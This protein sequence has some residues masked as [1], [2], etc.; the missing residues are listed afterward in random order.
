M[1]RIVAALDI[2]MPE[3]SL[4]LDP[5]RGI[6]APMAIARYAQS[7]PLVFNHSTCIAI[8][9]FFISLVLVSLYKPV[10]RPV[11]LFNSKNFCLLENEKTI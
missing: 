2:M 10:S 7:K 1:L 8:N 3:K 6:T 4:I 5:K 9:S 11:L